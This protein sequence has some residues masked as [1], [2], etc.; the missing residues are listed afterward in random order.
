VLLGPLLLRN[1]A[2]RRSIELRKFVR[3]AFVTSDWQ[4]PA[5]ITGHADFAC[6]TRMKSRL[7][8]WTIRNKPEKMWVIVQHKFRG[9]SRSQQRLS[10]REAPSDEALV[11][12]VE[13]EILQA[14][15]SS[16]LAFCS[17]VSI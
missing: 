17:A 2:V 8:M 7:V 13:L 4:S 5:F 10:P 9:L 6:I 14:S 16:I 12:E 15:S 3:R 11:A 1:A